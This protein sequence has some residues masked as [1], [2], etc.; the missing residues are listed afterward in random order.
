NEQGGAFFY[1]TW[2]DRFWLGG[3]SVFRGTPP[4]IQRM[5]LEDQEHLERRPSK[6]AVLQRE[7]ATTLGGRLIP[8]I[9]QRVLYVLEPANM[10]CLDVERG[11]AEAGSQPVEPSSLHKPAA[12]RNFAGLPQWM[13]FNPGFAVGHDPFVMF[14]LYDFEQKAIFHGRLNS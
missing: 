9:R 7:K 1:Q 10:R 12:T 14:Y 3:T 11:F 8:D 13:Y 6:Q 2:H 4:R 5:R